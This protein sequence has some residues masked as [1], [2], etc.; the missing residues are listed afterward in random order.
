MRATRL[1]ELADLLRAG[2]ETTIEALAAA[3]GVSARTVRRDVAVLRERGACIAGQSG[4]GGG[5]RLEGGRGLTAVHL[6]LG[7]LVALWL[8]AR[9]ADAGGERASGRPWTGHAERALG[10]LLAAVPASRARELRDLGARIFI[11][12]PANVGVR[13]SLGV[14]APDLLSLVEEAVV[15]SA[16]LRCAYRDRAGRTTSR[17]VEPHGLAVMP[18]AWYLLARDRTSGG[19]RMLRLDRILDPSLQR[20]SAFRP[21]SG[22]ARHLLPPEVTWQPLLRQSPV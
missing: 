18:P 3:L 22:L 9:L 11:G 8:T 4:R 15:A 2:G 1:L 20:T 6:G 19:A 17:H 12:P 13:D 10:K 5:V 14:L 7:E 16:S 21:D